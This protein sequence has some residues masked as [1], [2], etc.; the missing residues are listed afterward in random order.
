MDAFKNISLDDAKTLINTGNIIIADIRDPDSFKSGHIQ[1]AV[2]LSNDNL[3][4]FIRDSD[5]DT[6]VIVCCYHGH[7]SQPA[8][9][10]LSEQ[11]FD[12]VYS[13]IGGYTAWSAE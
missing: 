10:F 11:G 9:Q 7:S 3:Q 8:A 13:L 5:L 4:D 1:G 2:H 6:P 12:T